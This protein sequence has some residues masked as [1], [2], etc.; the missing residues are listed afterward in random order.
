MGDDAWR[1]VAALE[2]LEEL[3]ED[4]F[5]VSADRDEFVVYLWPFPELS[6][7][8]HRAIRGLKSELVDLLD[9]EPPEGPCPDCGTINYTRRPAGEWRC[10]ECWPLTAREASEYFFGPLAWAQEEEVAT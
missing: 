3:L 7:E 9:P 5:G 6:A 10:M 8:R 1:R 2:L 4:G